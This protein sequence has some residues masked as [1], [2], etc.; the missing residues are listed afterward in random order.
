MINQVYTEE[1]LDA[2]S[3]DELNFTSG[4]AKWRMKSA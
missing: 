3:Q 4:G 1:Q 2:M